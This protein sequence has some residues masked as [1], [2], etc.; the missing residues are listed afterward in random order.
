MRKILF[1]CSGNT[2]RSPLAL[3]A[4][5]ALEETGKTP[6]EIEADSAG[7]LASDGEKA[8]K[9][10]LEIARAWNQDLST[11]RSKMLEPEAAAQA[12]WIVVM[13]SSHALALQEY[14]GAGPKK[15]FLLGHFDAKNG[16]DEI[17]DPF[18]GSREG[19]ETCAVRIRCAVENLAQAIHNDEL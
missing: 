2:C 6:H 10:T 3:A 1:L 9:H 13:N 12:D 4:W 11:H 18:G 15:V 16:D 19:Y 17:L 14:F 8:T 7:L 5:R